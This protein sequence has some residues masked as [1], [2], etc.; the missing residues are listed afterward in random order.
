MP[1]FELKKVDASSKIRYFKESPIWSELACEIAD[2]FEIP[3][4]RVAVTYLEMEESGRPSHRQQP[5]R[6]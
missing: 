6:P 5:E 1:L 4:K 2:T 3:Y